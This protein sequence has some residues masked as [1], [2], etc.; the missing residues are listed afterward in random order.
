MIEIPLLL[1]RG[2][3]L[4]SVKADAKFS[5]KLKHDRKNPRT[6][7][8]DTENELFQVFDH[9]YLALIIHC[10]MPNAER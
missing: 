10:N 9:G 1:V 2:N 5:K 3:P 6:P 7:N 8:P 4:P